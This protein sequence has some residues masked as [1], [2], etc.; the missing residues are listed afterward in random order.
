MK[1][2][3]TTTYL[4]NMGCNSCFCVK[5]QMLDSFN[6]FFLLLTLKYIY[7]YTLYT[8]KHV[9]IKSQVFPFL[10]CIFKNEE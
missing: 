8:L 5:I 9:Y 1:S 7:I 3:K 4:L 10:L 2:I 6:E